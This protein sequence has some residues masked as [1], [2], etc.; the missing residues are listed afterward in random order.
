VIVCLSA[1]R[2]VCAGS[3]TH[4]FWARTHRCCPRPRRH[5]GGQLRTAPCTLRKAA[6]AVRTTQSPANSPTFCLCCLRA[7]VQKVINQFNRIAQDGRVELLCNV[8]VGQDVMLTELRQLYDAVRMCSKAFTPAGCC[9]CSWHCCCHSCS[10]CVLHDLQQL[11]GDSPCIVSL[12][13]L[14]VLQHSCIPF[15]PRQFNPPCTRCK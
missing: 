15:N 14:G 9:C 5:Q 7:V 12:M 13:S 11:S 1:P 6:I 10:E 4:T 8:R 3:I 2:R